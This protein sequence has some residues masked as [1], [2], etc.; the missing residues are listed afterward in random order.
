MVEA[1]TDAYFDESDVFGQWLAECCALHP[2]TGHYETAA[3]LYR[4]WT[5][6][7]KQSGHNPGNRTSFGRALGKVDG[8]TKKVSGTVR[9]LGIK[10]TQ[11]PRTDP[12]QGFPAR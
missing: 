12:E 10:L 2:G 7:A 1:A 8:L 11:S 5:A 3:D 9:W 4:S 6:W